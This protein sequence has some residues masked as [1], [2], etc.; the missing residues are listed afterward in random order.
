MT[1]KQADTSVFNFQE[2]LNNELRNSFIDF[3]N[4]LDSAAVN[5][6]FANKSSVNPAAVKG[7]FNATNHAY[8]IVDA[9][10]GNQAMTITKAVM[11]INK[12]QGQTMNI[13]CDSASWTTFL[14]QAAQG[15]QNAT[16]L[17]F[18]FMGT[19]FVHAPQLAA[20]AVALD[21]TYIKGF[22]MAVPQSHVACLDWIPT[23]NRQGVE[24][25]VSM[26]GSIMNPVDSLQYA[27]H[28]Y[29]TR[30]DGTSVNGQ[31]QDVSTES[32]ISI[33][34]SF[35][36]SPSSTANETPIQAFALK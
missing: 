33:D 16:N 15:A 3:A 29:E 21:A 27:L 5:Y 34:L 23:Q 17:S 31:V 14:Q 1:L 18:Q 22:W 24:N 19:N 9:T 13:V 20:L 32:E 8:E 10:Y 36:Y 7:T 28:S 2:Q 4:G 12:Y 25:T 35:Q 30:I 26:Y 11:D 6:L